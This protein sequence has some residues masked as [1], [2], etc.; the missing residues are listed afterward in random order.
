MRWHC[1]QATPSV[2]GSPDLASSMKNWTLSGNS[3]TCGAWQRKH[4]ALSL[5]AGDAKNAS[6]EARNAGEWIDRDKGEDSHSSK[7]RSWQRLHLLEFGKALS[8]VMGA[9]PS[10]CA[11]S[12][13]PHR[14]EAAPPSSTTPATTIDRPALCSTL[15]IPLCLQRVFAR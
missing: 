5:P 4:S 6:S 10:C 2:C 9:L 13:S 12:R 7:T 14:C 8:I 1:E 11:N 3:R 15:R